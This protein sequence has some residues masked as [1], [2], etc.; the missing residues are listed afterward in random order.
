M[1]HPKVIEGRAYRVSLVHFPWYKF[2]LVHTHHAV[3]ALHDLPEGGGVGGASAVLGGGARA[4]VL[5]RGRIHSV[6]S[7]LTHGG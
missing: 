3:P 6:D 4:G 2:T 7:V 5:E 1:I